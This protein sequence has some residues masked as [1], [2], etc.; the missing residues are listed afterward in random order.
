MS[1]APNSLNGFANLTTLPGT[2]DLNTIA[3]NT[4]PF[5]MNF[6][7][8]ST[9]LTIQGNTIQEDGNNTL[10]YKG[11]QYNLSTTT[12]CKPTT[13]SY[14]LY[15]TAVKSKSKGS[16]MFTF[17]INTIGTT[18]TSYSSA[19]QQKTRPKL[20]STPLAIILILPVFQGDPTTNA[21]YLTQ[22][23]NPPTDTNKFMSMQGLFKNLKCIGYSACIDLVVKPNTSPTFGCPT[24]IYNF[25]D[26][27]AIQ[28]DLNL[29]VKIQPPPY[30]F[31]SGSSIIQSYNPDGSPIF[32]GA[33][34]SPTILPP[35][36]IADD[37]FK[38]KMIYY[39]L[40]IAT[41]KSSTAKPTNLTPEQYQ[42]F[43][44][45]ELQN[46]QKDNAGTKTVGRLG[47]V[48]RS[49]DTQ[50][51]TVGAMVS[52][53]QIKV[54]VI[55]IGSLIVAFIGTSIFIW[56]ITYFSDNKLPDEV[57][58]AAAAATAV[59]TAAGTAPP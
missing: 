48:I 46:L 39:L 7:P 20:S 43:P 34:A 8:R 10:L 1:C 54:F 12:I 30:T 11:N 25:T 33:S 47:E 26:G 57:T 16:L 4:Y 42:C 5:I 27:I 15:G 21:A 49:Q 38:D 6:A 59:G 41:P 52:W 3:V 31:I 22:I 45:D 14:E 55:S 24:Q 37:N 53:D 44:F 50:N 28:G 56:A 36:S 9:P 23:P 17:L 19:I 58:G 13:G 35:I 51:N 18:I 29:I 2:S 32:T 40:P